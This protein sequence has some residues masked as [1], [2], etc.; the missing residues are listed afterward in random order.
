LFSGALSVFRFFLVFLGALLGFSL[1]VVF[2]V[3]FRFLGYVFG[4]FCWV[5]VWVFLAN[6]GSPVY[7]TSIRRSALRF[8]FNE[9]L[10]IKKKKKILLEELCDFDIIDKERALGVEERMKEAEV[11]SELERFTLME[12]VS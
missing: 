10:L 5:F 12:E 3:L 8:H 6:F 11:V 4:A 7:T 9:L 1:W 2:W